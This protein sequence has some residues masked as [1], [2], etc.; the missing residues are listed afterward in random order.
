MTVADLKR[1]L[2]KFPLSSLQARVDVPALPHGHAPS[3]QLIV[4]R[5]RT[6]RP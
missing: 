5:T 6:Q 4:T 2:R 3:S 1:G